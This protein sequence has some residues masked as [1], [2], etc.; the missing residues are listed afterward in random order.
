MQLLDVL[1]PG[2][3][4][5]E[6]A[7]ALACT[8]S[9]V[10]IHQ[11]EVRS[12]SGK[13]VHQAS[14]LR[15]STLISLAPLILGFILST[16]LFAWSKTLIETDL[17]LGLVG[18]WIAFSVAFHSIPSS[19]D[20]ANISGAISRRLNELW[21]STHSLPH[22]LVKSGWYVLVWPLAILGMSIAWI[23]DL[24]LLARVAWALFVGWIA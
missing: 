10:P 8:I 19:A 6:V 12:R 1:F 5:H 9:G 21:K 20:M 14:N 24:T 18:L 7:H 22:K 11:V 23:V 4:V 2:V 3:F 16:L 13:V 15:N 17:V